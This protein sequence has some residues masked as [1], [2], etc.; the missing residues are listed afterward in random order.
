[1]GA[2]QGA[3]GHPGQAGGRAQD[4][5]QDESPGKEGRRACPGSTT[6]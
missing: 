2:G 5:Q 4:L 1:V 6:G 3:P